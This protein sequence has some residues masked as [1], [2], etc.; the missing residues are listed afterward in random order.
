MKPAL[1]RLRPSG[2]VAAASPRL[3]PNPPGQA[4]RAVAGEASEGW[5]ARQETDRA[6]YAA[7]KNSYLTD[8]GTLIV[9]QCCV[10]EW[11]ASS[12]GPAQG[13]QPATTDCE[14]IAGN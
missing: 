3:A 12:G 2:S 9:V 6:A 4:C 14:C 7:C 13:H 11:K 1:A 8:L 5:W 10:T